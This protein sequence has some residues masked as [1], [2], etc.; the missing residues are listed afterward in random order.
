MNKWC[1]GSCATY[2]SNIKLEL[3]DN[4]KLEFAWKFS[5]DAA[6]VTNGVTNGL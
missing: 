2:N 1:L 6:G 3:P 5:D 4:I